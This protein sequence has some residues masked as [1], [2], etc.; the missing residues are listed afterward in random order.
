[1]ITYWYSLSCSKITIVV[2]MV[3]DVFGYVN[4]RSPEAH[5]FCMSVICSLTRRYIDT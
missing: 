4:V 2:D 1:M 5:L 3:S